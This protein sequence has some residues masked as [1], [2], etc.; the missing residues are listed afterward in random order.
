MKL[1][2]DFLYREYDVAEDVARKVESGYYREHYGLDTSEV[3]DYHYFRTNKEYSHTHAQ[4]RVY[5]IRGILITDEKQK[6]IREKM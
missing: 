4:I 1:K 2:N 6:I 3:S 5:M